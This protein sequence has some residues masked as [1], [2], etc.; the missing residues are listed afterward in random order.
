[1]L[2]EMGSVYG[3]GGH[4]GNDLESEFGISP[5]EES[6]EADLVR[7]AGATPRHDDRQ[8]ASVRESAGRDL[9]L[10]FGRLD[11]SRVRH[12]VGDGDRLTADPLLAIGYQLSAYKNRRSL[13]CC[14][15]GRERIA[16]RP[17]RN[18]PNRVPPA[19]LT[20]TAFEDPELSLQTDSQL[21]TGNGHP[22]FQLVTARVKTED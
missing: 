20:A 14:G 2:R 19:G 22:H 7:A 12:E 5:G 21:A 4:S 18:K 9:S 11:R 6:Q 10:G 8:L 17:R 15:R 3:S 1:M 13:R 16:D